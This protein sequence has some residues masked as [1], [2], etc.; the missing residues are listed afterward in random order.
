LEEARLKMEYPNRQR[1][2]KDLFKKFTGK[3]IERY[4]SAGTRSGPERLVR[5]LY[6]EPQDGCLPNEF[7]GEELLY[8]IQSKFYQF[9]SAIT[10]AV[11]KDFLDK[12]GVKGK[13]LSIWIDPSYDDETHVIVTFQS[14]VVLRYSAK[15]WN[16][17]WPS[18][19]ELEKEMAE[20]Y[21]K[22]RDAL[23]A[24]FWEGIRY[25]EEKQ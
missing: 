20:L 14:L 19:R 12:Q 23:V 8:D 18:V 2:E 16:F 1:L 6:L 21:Y 15:A 11:E 25:E 24:Y 3:I 22:M 7:I 4:G 10:E 13:W 9:F 17:A 5:K